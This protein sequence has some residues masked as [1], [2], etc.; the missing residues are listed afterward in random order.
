MILK[1]IDFLGG[2]TGR[3]VA[4]AGI[5]GALIGLRTWDVMHQRSVGRQQEQV[6]VEKV[7]KRIDERAQ[8]KRERVQQAP[9]SEVDAALRK[10]CRD[11]GK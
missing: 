5:I 7:G 1:A 4:I 10:F 9:P 6:R 2:W 11:C 8:K 3:A